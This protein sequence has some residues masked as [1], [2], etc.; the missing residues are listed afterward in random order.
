MLIKIYKVPRSEKFYFG[1]S[2]N[3]MQD[4]FESNLNG[5]EVSIGNAMM[6][7]HQTQMRLK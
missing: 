5:I 6:R 3:L 4:D 1:D 2:L 7:L